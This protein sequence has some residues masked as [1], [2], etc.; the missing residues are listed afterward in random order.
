MRMIPNSTY[1]ENADDNLKE[2]SSACSLCEF[3]YWWRQGCEILE[4][5]IIWAN[6]VTHAAHAATLPQYWREQTESKLFFVSDVRQISP[7]FDYH[8][9]FLTV[10]F[11]LGM[12]WGSSA[13]PSQNRI[14][15][16][17]LYLS[18]FFLQ[19][20]LTAGQE[21]VRQSGNLAFPKKFCTNRSRK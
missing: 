8:E 5:A 17:N 1:I 3:C 16:S 15:W 20:N 4:R 21:I 18:L 12:N 11:A 7:A 14:N 10:R 9:C 2:T 6:T 13:T 19:N